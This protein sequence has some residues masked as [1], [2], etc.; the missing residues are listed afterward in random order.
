M[1]PEQAEG[2]NVDARSDVFSFGSVLY[3][4]L[5]G[6]RA[7]RGNSPASKL[8]NI[9]HNDPRPAREI[10]GPLPRDL[11]TLLS[12]CLRK[13]PARRWQSM[14]DVSVALLDL[15]EDSRAR[16]PLAAPSGRLARS[17][18][19]P[20]MLA[21][22]GMIAA[23]ALALFHFNEQPPERGVLRYTLPFPDKNSDA[24]EFAIS[25]DCRYLA[26]DAGGEGSPHRLWVRAL[27]SLSAQPLAGT[28]DAAYPF[29][30]PDSHWI[31]FF[32]R[33]KPKKISANG[34]PVQTLCDAPTGRGGT[35]GPSG[36]IVFAADNG[37]NGLSRVS[38]T[39]GTP[40][41]VTRV[42][43]GTHRWPWFLPDGRHFLYLAARGPSN[44]IHLAS[45]DSRQDKRLVADESNPAFDQSG[46]LLFVRERTLMAQP[47]DPKTLDTRGELFPV[48]EQISQGFV[49]GS[50]L[51]SVSANGVL[52]YQNGRAAEG[53]Q[54][55]WFDRAGKEMTHAGGIMRSLN[56][57][58]VWPDGK[59]L[60]TEHPSDSGSGTDLWLADLTHGPQ[61]GNESRFTFD[62]SLN[63]SPVWSPDGARIAF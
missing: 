6:E 35:W 23:A 34:G 45:L 57:F 27:D 32:S 8:G 40:A 46:F 16:Q 48:A 12:R 7:F 25:P 44:G 5:T 21:A 26:M 4:M 54:H 24:R 17:S 36:V 37:N 63:S 18:T 58:S 62:P 50:K 14:A 3:E 19:L 2:Q 1:S 49:Y 55:T 42:E 39:G 51:Y 59:R 10:L 11:E 53:R 13:D 60:A 28:D 20:W 61:L 29:W 52:V 41:L 31:A 33:D 22:A 56:S 15:K 30:S 9:I 47:V 38:E 43:L